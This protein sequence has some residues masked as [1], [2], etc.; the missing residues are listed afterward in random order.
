[1]LFTRKEER[2]SRSTDLLFFRQT[3][4]IRSQSRIFWSFW[5]AAPWQPALFRLL[6]GHCREDLKVLVVAVIEHDQELI[7]PLDAGL[8]DLLNGLQAGEQDR[9]MRRAGKIIVERAVV[10]IGRQDITGLDGSFQLA[11]DALQ[12]GQ[13]AVGALLR[14]QIGDPALDIFAGRVDRLDIDLI[15]STS[16]SMGFIKRPRSTDLTNVPFPCLISTRPIM[17][18]FF[19]ASRTVMRLTENISQSAGSG[20]S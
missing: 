13:L 10:F 5:H 15:K 11:E 16:C 1:M 8:I 4:A 20:G 3:W 17:L 6:I 9:V 14:G 2:G 7:I 19:S 12:N 18:S